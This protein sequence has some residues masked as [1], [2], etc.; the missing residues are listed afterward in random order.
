MLTDLKAI[1]SVA[2]LSLLACTRPNPAFVDS[3]GEEAET[4]ADGSDTKPDTS[5]TVADGP[6]ETAD[7][8]VSSTDATDSQTSATSSDE[9][10]T[11]DVERES[12]T[13]EDN[14]PLHL[15]LYSE[16]GLEPCGETLSAYFVVEGPSGNNQILAQPCSAGCETCNDGPGVELEAWPMDLSELATSLQGSCVRAE[17]ASLVNSSTTYCE[18]DKAVFYRLLDFQEEIPV[19]IGSS[20]DGEVPPPVEALFAELGLLWEFIGFPCECPDDDPCCLPDDPPTAYDYEFE[21]ATVL[22][23]GD[24]HDF[25][26]EGVGT[27]TFHARESEYVNSCGAEF[28]ASWVTYL[29][30]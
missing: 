16:A 24:T 22:R 7:A 5:D 20:H 26:V 29:H 27:W 21:D 9:E 17:F 12:C 4:T 19:L 1:G 14:D 2:T 11:L 15:K 28:E 6:T 3:V 10:G 18:W 8:E 23:P 13:V 25:M 30:G